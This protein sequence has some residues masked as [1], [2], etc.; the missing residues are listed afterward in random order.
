MEE[1]A[2]YQEHLVKPEEEQLREIEA[3]E[4]AAAGERLNAEVAPV[5][6]R[7]VIIRFSGR[8]SFVQCMHGVI[9]FS[10]LVFFCCI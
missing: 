10:F 3:E 4:R 5:E 1:F 2:E 7:R 8:A 6:E 9:H